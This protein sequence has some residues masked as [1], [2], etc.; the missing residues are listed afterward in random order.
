MK[1]FIFDT[2][3]LRQ[4]KIKRQIEVSENFTLYNLAE[5]AVNAYGFSFDHAFGFFDEITENLMPASG[6]RYELFTDIPDVESTGAGSVEHTKVY[7]V[8]KKVGD[9][10]MMLFDYGDDW[11]FVV[12]LNGFGEAKTQKKF[13]KVLKKIGEAPEQ[14]PDYE[15]E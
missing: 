4:K 6:K 14:Y 7:D 15:E 3:L 11:R 2:K 8:W 1:T 13:S 5:V 12:E 10:M 9:Q